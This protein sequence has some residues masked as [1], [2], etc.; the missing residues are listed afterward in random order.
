M[1]RPGYFKTISSVF[2]FIA[3]FLAVSNYLGG[4]GS[5]ITAAAFIAIVVTIL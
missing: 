2:V 5:G 1:E 4:G 3:A